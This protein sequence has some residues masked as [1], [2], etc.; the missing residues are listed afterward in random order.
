MNWGK[1][2]FIVFILFAAG[3]GMMAYT[4]M[5]KNIDLV[6]QNYYE[7]EIKYQEQIDK[8]NNTGKSFKKLQISLTLQNI[9]IVFPKGS[10]GGKIS[11]EII[12][13]RPSDAKADFTIP[14]NLNGNSVQI[15]PTD[16]LIKGMWKVMVTWSSEDVNYYSEERIMIP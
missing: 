4:S 12:F 9:V 13:Y 10:E 11:G 15:I 8:I 2:I 16:N 1:G 5:I 7:K 6:S 14:V 3:I